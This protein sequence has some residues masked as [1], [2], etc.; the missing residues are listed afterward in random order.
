MTTTKTALRQ[1]CLS[2]RAQLSAFEKETYSNKIFDGLQHTI[3]S[4]YTSPINILC[5][6][7]IANEVDTSKYFQQPTQHQLYAP[8]THA[9][10]DMKWL[11]VHPNSTWQQGMFGILEPIKG[12]IWQANEIPT[13]LLC[14][15]VGFDRQGNRIGMG[16]GCFDRW[17][18]AHQQHID[19]TIGLAFSCQ[20]CNSI[21]HE[22]HDIALHAI[23]TEEGWITCP[24]T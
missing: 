17:L 4:N 23:I 8:Q 3:N 16:K 13:I 2:K 7:S 12:K 24:S 5:Y 9:S 18:A 15:V 11:G 21:E 10:G 20:E 6:R 14:P 19:I 22:A 1:S